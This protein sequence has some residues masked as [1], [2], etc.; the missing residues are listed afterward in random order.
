MAVMG[1]P[2]AGD[3]LLVV[4]VCGNGFNV[5]QHGCDWCMLVH[6][7]LMTGA[8]QHLVTENILGYLSMYQN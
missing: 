8:C 6:V 7:D 3:S 4:P 5:H 2:T 1:S